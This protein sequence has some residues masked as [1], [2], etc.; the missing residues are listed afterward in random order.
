MKKWI[1]LL[2][3]V[4]LLLS[5]AACGSKLE[6]NGPQEITVGTK[7]PIPE[8]TG[9]AAAG[10]TTGT[11]EDVYSYV[12]EDVELIPGAAFDVSELPEAE[13]VYTVPSCALEGTD[14]V[15]SYG[16]LEVT[17]F[18]DGKGEFIY[19]V[20]LLDPNL[21]TA[22]GLAQGDTAAKVTELYGEEYTENGTEWIYQKGETLLCVLFQDGTVIGIEYRLET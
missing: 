21:T 9:A 20:Y 11:A 2:I 5:L 13:S 8:T 3:S 10:E 1:A 19:S 4:V 17:A 6:D 7:A 15:Y 16:T 22:E 18:N 12:F 14:N